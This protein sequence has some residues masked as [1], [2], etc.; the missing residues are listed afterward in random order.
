MDYRIIIV[1]M[2]VIVQVRLGSEEEHREWDG[3]EE[4]RPTLEEVVKVEE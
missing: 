3:R 1:L 4:L 2:F